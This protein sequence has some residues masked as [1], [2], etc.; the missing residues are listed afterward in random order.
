MTVEFLGGES[1]P[2]LSTAFSVSGQDAT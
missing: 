1:Y 2:S